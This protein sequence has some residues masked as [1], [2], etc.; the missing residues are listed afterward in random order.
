MHRTTRRRLTGL[1]LAAT[2]SV[3]VAACG[4]S[5]DSG[6]AGSETP[7]NEESPTDSPAA[8]QWADD[9]CSDVADW[10]AVLTQARETLANPRELSVAAVEGTFDEVQTA[11]AALVEELRGLEAPD[12]EA[13]DEAS[14]RVS[15]L[16]DDLA[17]QADAVGE[18]TAQK[19]E[20]AQQRL[21]QVST[22]TGAASTMASETKAAVSDLR[23]LDG[24]EELQAAFADADSCQGLG[25]CTSPARQAAAGG[26]TDGRRAFQ[27]R[28]STRLT[29]RMTTRA[30]VVAG[31]SSRVVATNETSTT[32]VVR[33]ATTSSHSRAPVSR[34]I[35]TC[36]SVTRVKTTSATALPIEAMAV[37][38]KKTTSTRAVTSV[39]HDAHRGSATQPL[40]HERRELPRRDHPV[41]EPGRREESRVRRA[42]RGEQR[43]DRHHPVAGRAEDRLGRHRQRGP[44]RS[45]S[46]R[47]R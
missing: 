6:D 10:N 40:A 24:A 3:P 18:A 7:T 33:S 16:A 11:T 36:P 22:V 25:S 23:T 9:V 45:R 26:G 30:T 35:R 15:D 20:D 39:T 44:A 17:Q 38:S 43:G 28:S 14:Q 8:L 34:R 41:P 46:P 47:R 5:D 29:S 4:G 42:G 2:L 32:T 21:A 13:G 37:R 31:S 19:P 27:A 12:T 1:C